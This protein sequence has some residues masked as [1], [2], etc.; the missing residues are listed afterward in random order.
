MERNS[1]P[2]CAICEM[3]FDKVTLLQNRLESTSDG[4]AHPGEQSEQPVEF[5]GALL[6]L[7]TLEVS[8]A[9]LRSIYEDV[10]DRFQKVD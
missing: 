8:P 3:T 6:T 9:S 5:N 1:G 2:F 10:A 7:E 4:D